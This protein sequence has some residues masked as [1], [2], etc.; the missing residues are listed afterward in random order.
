MSDWRRAAKVLDLTSSG[1]ACLAD[2]AGFP[3]GPRPGPLPLWH[4]GQGGEIARAYYALGGR[5]EVVDQLYRAFVGRRPGRVELLSDDAE[6]FV[7]GQLASFVREVREAGAADEDVPDLFYLLRRMPTWAGPSHGCVEWVRDTTSPLWSHRLLKHELG[8]PARERVHEEFHRRVLE[9]LNRQLL[10]IPYESPARAGRRRTLV[11]KAFA[12]LRRRGA[13]PV[14]PQDDSFARILP[15]IRDVVLS[16]AEHPAWPLLD[17]A[18]V[19]ELL[20]APPASLDTMSR[21]YAWRL[22]TVFGADA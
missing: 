11:R 1:T 13:A 21:Y 20:A 12:E 4:S 19:D 18:R 7:R 17:R 6:Y 3:I 14:E 10:D 5:G 22:A 15:E 8:L 16:Q 9:V 2:A